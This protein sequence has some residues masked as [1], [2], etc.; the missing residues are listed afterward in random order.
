MRLARS[1]YARSVRVRSFLCGSIV[2]LCAPG[3][4][5]AQA[6]VLLGG[7]LTTPL[8]TFRE[9]TDAGYH[10]RAAFQLGIPTI[11]ISVR[12]DAAY[13]RL[14]EADPTF[15]AASILAGAVDVVYSMP[16]VGLLPYLLVGVGR[17]RVRGGP[18]GMA[19]TVYRNGFALGFG[20][21]LGSGPLG[22]FV[23]IR[24]AQIAG[25]PSAT[26]YVPVTVGL[27]L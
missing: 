23:E 21:G 10:A 5:S 13:H 2:L 24:Y 16:G 18:D 12:L 4:G 3:S 8:G 14:A 20:V 17:H 6:S 19:R 22:G 25:E 7:G 27:R 9:T 15:E 26:K 1:A 11:P